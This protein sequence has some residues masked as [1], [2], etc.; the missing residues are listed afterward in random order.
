MSDTFLSLS[1]AI[2]TRRLFRSAFY[3]IS[4]AVRTFQTHISHQHSIIGRRYKES[5]LGCW[6]YC[7]YISAQADC[8]AVSIYLLR[9]ATSSNT[10]SAAQGA[11]QLDY[12]MSSP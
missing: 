9:E 8:G 6:V 10:Y 7:T 4:C 3:Y 1:C 11:Y 12:V 2:G 5:I